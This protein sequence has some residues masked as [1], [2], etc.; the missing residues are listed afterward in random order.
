MHTEDVLQRTSG[1]PK[2]SADDRYGLD[3]LPSLR[4]GKTRQRPEADPTAPVPTPRLVLLLGDGSWGKSNQF[5]TVVEDAI[6]LAQEGQSENVD[7]AETDLEM[8]LF[9][10][11]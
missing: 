1:P 2:P 11:Q 6:V 5:L 9:I 10:L 8:V 4:N 3:P 7:R